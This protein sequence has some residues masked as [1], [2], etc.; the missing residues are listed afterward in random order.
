M[1]KIIFSSVFLLLIISVFAFEPASNLTKS[2]LSGKI[3]DLHT[4]ETIPGV[5]IYFPDLKTGTISKSD[6]TYSVTRLPSAKLLVQVSFIGY[7]IIAETIDLSKTTRMD[8]NMEPAVTE[9]SE[10]VVT[11]QSG[12]VGKDRTPTPIA[13]IAPDYLRQNSATNIIDALASKAGISQITTGSAISKPVIRGLG[14]NR[15]VVVDD[16][17]R[18][19]GQQWGDEHGIEIDEFSINRAEILKGP[20]SLAYGSD[21]MAG[22]I[23]LMSAPT[24]PEGAIRGEIQSNFQT[25]NGLFGNSVDFSG[26]KKGLIWDLRASD[27]RAH[28]YQN[29]YDGPVYNSGFTENALSGIIGVNKEWGYSHLHLSMYQLKPGIVEGE[30]DSISGQFVKPAPDGE[31]MIAVAQSD[32]KKYVPSVP[33]QLVSHYKAVFDNSLFLKGGN[34]KSTIGFQQN[35][36]KE[37]ADVTVPNVYQLYFLLN[38]LNYN[39]QFSFAEKNNFN[40]SL[41]LSGMWQDSK[42]KG[43][44]FLVPAYSLFD[45]G[46]FGIL[47]KTIGKF[48]LM[49]GIR[50]DRR[51]QKGQALYLNDEEQPVDQG[52]VG[53]TERF[54]AFDKNLYGLS[55]SLGSSW[56][57]SKT[58]YTKL[59]VAR[60]FR[61]PNIGELGS[62]GIHEGTLRYEKGNTGLKPESSFQVDY[63]IG[64]HFKHLA[65]ELNLFTNS[66]DNFIYSHKQTDAN[67]N[68]VFIE[69]LPVFMFTSGKALL[70]GGEFTLD[71]HPHPFDWLHFENSFSYVKATLQNQPDSMRNLPLTPPFHW[72]SDIKTEFGKLFGH[73]DNTYLKFGIDLY[74]RQNQIFSAYD[75]ETA[76]PGYFLLNFGA[77]TDFVSG[78]KTLF[79]VYL[80]ANNLADVAY[81]SHLSRLKYADKNNATGR[82]GIFNMG[83]NISIKLL[84]PIDFSGIE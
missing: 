25:N 80:T 58:V 17:I 8:F 9:I 49:G 76:T 41:G 26:N 38:T 27:K 73:L 32:Y 28:A 56:Q 12:G 40:A 16:G 18:Q 65:S 34:L 44:E 67:G 69:N 46:V 43:S 19:E 78:K 4:G 77:G 30:R 64:M 24:L 5:T 50:V 51:W 75:T 79:S 74:G 66:V 63:T 62:N 33:Y 3:T 20:A 82:T 72:T 29:K 57:I 48:D 35:Q 53:A 15:V 47:K 22:V 1:Y 10:V 42:N 2:S 21:A 59:N 36:R 13:T 71:L 81:Q 23:N 39:F 70:R 83:R 55:G 54:A 37:F 7:Q 31:S 45:A 84:I 52:T 61:A 68:P 11:G 14:Y 60:G 6:G